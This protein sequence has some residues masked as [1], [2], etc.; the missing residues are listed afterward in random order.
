MEVVGIA[1]GRGCYDEYKP[2]GIGISILEG[3][4]APGESERDG[5]AVD[6]GDLSVRN[7]DA[8]ADARRLLALPYM[9]RLGESLPILEA[10]EDAAAGDHLVDRSMLLIRFQEA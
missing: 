3:D 9:D 5:G 7:G 10:G 2:H 4:A 8:M 6:T 1:A